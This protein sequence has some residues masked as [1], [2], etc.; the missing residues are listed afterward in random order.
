MHHKLPAS[1]EPGWTIAKTYATSPEI[2]I[3]DSQAAYEEAYGPDN[4]MV[5]VFCE[6]N[7][8]L[9]MSRADDTDQAIDSFDRMFKMAVERAQGG[10]EA[11][12]SCKA[13]HLKFTRNVDDA[14]LQVGGSS[15]GPGTSKVS[16]AQGKRKLSSTR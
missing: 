5:T 13:L 3:R 7:D 15:S 2:S 16:A 6:I 9:D 8:I 11:Y 10:G 14:A 1:S 12:T 4:D